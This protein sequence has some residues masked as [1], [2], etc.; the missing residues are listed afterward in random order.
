MRTSAS[1]FLIGELERRARIVRPAEPGLIR[2]DHELIAGRLER[3]SAGITPGDERLLD[4][5]PRALA[6]RDE[7]A[8]AIHEQHPTH[9]VSHPIPLAAAGRCRLAARR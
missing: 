8:V 1:R 5:S 3:S 6:L 4:G 7:R 2:H 9:G